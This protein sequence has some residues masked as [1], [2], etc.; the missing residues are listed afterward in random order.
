[1]FGSR[2][3]NVA[4]LALLTLLG[5]CSSASA[6]D[7]YVANSGNGTVSVIESATNT[8]VGAIPVGGEPV[9]IAITPNGRYAWVV[10]AAGGSVSTSSTCTLRVSPRTATRPLST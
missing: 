2:R 7:V 8:A 5:L 3:I 10:D 1:M 4:C 6:R 9:D